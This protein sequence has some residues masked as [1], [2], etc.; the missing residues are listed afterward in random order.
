MSQTQ[1]QDM[2]QESQINAV[3]GA[4]DDEELEVP[5]DI[6]ATIVRLWDVAKEQHWR[7]FV[8]S[9]SIV[10]YV[11][12]ALAGPMYTAYLL[13]LLWEKIQAAFTRGENFRIGWH[14]G[15]MQ[16]AI[17]LLIYTLEWAFY[18]TQTLIMASFAERINLKLRNAV[19]DKL[20][21]LPLR[22]YDA[23]QP[24]RIISRVTN[25]LDKMS[26]VMQTGL[27]RLL[28]A[29]GQVTGAVVMM[30][31]INVWLALVFV[32]FA[33]FSMLVTRL[34]SRKTL[35][36][37]A[38]RQRAVGVLTGHVEEAYSGRAIIR[39]FNQEGSSAARIHEA[40][41]D[42]A[43]ATR[44]ADFMTNAISPAIRLIV[45]LSQVAIAV[46]AGLMLAAGQLTVGVFQA[47]FQYINQASEPL[48]QMSFT[49]NSLQSA[50][51][52]VERVFDILDADEI[53]PEPDEPE[54]VSEPVSGR[55]D[56]EHVR[57]G[58]DADRPL[59]KDV[60]F[61]AE[62]GHRTAIVGATGAGK[63]TLINLL[64]RFYE[65][66]GGHIRLDGADTHRMNRADLRA[67]FGMV[68]QDAWL[69]DGTIAE[70]IAYG[71]P[72]ATREE[73]VAA[74]KM[75]RVDYFV[76]T[77]PEGYDTRLANDA[78]NISQGQRQLLT[79]A[80]VILCDPKIL[81][82]DEA[83][84]SVD[85]HTEQEIGKAMDA[86]MHGRTS[87]VIAHRLSTIVDADL[88]L[89]MDHG[90]II[91]QGTHRELLAADGA[92]ARLYNSQFA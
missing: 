33:A 44:R 74:A 50:L 52:S 69:F 32:V 3:A 89:V 29:V 47:F 22:Y 65:I 27:L 13:D 31:V 23:N 60:T 92:Y 45:R 55:V 80:R 5:R 38:E 56:F 10:C 37:A 54:T 66:D 41:R 6:K 7:I 4:A 8:V 59:M 82:L 86:L 43:D 19:G 53:E 67:N 28:V 12:A 49:I 48:T 36:L 84:S 35:V 81:I 51:A 42:V 57:F 1:Q 24:G 75:A 83:T 87:F 70:N 46:M 20:T 58:Y 88:I 34:V 40:T 16:I 15:G 21:R 14:D 91:E 73:I 68:L 76:R 72:E 77:L 62:P 63:T 9:A 26:E 2:T 39:S 30:V 11:V 78:E 71:R 85:T 18:S 17:L 64:M 79:I 90:T 61:T 25:D